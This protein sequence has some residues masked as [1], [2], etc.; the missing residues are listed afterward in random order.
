M[1]AVLSTP[2][3]SPRGLQA[4]GTCSGFVNNFLDGIGG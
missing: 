4:S 2:A 3:T 1:S